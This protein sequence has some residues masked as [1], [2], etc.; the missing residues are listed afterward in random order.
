MVNQ[1][2]SPKIT[3]DAMPDS[4][5][6]QNLP[7]LPWRLENGARI[8][9]DAALRGAI[10]Q[11]GEYEFWCAVAVAVGL[12]LEVAV[13]AFNPPYNSFWERFGP[14]ISDVLVFAGVLGEYL[15]NNRSQ[16]CQEELTRRSND[17]LAKAEL[18]A[19]EARARTAEVEKL[20]AWRH[21]S[22][23]QREVI[24]S[25]V[26]RIGSDNINLLVEYQ[27][28]D[29]EAF[30]LSRELIRAFA[31]VG[32]TKI[33]WR[34]NS[35]TMDP[36]FGFHWASSDP[37]ISVELLRAAMA[38]G[39]GLLIAVDPATHLKGANP[40]PTPNLYAFIGPKPPVIDVEAELAEMGIAITPTSDRNPTA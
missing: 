28:F 6:S 14:V 18:E 10:G 15:V 3:N 25:E 1:I 38:S 32:V 33:R 22:P 34:P 40:L 13:A 37:N 27:N 7:L 39:P 8:A 29:A 17:R 21:I 24:E 26:S 9:S 12:G 36:V 31:R 11:C 19:A 30:M 2:R 20:T 35:Y 23:E 5:A 16:T 4:G